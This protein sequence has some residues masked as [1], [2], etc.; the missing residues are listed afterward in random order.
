MPCVFSDDVRE[1]K[2]FYSGFAMRKLGLI[3]VESWF[4]KVFYY[5]FHLVATE[6]F[7]KLA[8]MACL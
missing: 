3:G 1:I 5:Q 6:I 8:Y 4:V 2:C 7:G